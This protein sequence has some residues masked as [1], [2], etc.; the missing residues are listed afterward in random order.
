VDQ[1]LT[2]GFG[3]PQEHQ[4]P[5]RIPRGVNE[6]R[7]VVEAPTDLRPAFQPNHRNDNRPRKQPTDSIPLPGFEPG[8]PP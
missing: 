1:P 7:I 6:G 3:T 8:F 4:N 5:L 2:A